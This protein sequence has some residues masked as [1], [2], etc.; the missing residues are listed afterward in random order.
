MQWTC[1]VPNLSNVPQLTPTANSLV[2]MP[3]YTSHSP[4]LYKLL[5]PYSIT[6][7]LPSLS[8]LFFAPPPLF[9]FQIYPLLPLRT[10]SYTLLT[11][12]PPPLFT[13][14]PSSAI[15]PLYASPCPTCEVS[16][17]VLTLTLSSLLTVS[18]ST[19][20]FLLIRVPFQSL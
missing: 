2:L 11:S 16:G 12:P 3:S 17:A 8:D 14:A 9:K 7:N 20:L 13:S 19:S 18:P 5:S 10:L 15:C 6:I 4:G 1:C